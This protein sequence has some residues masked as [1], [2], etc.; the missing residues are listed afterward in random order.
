MRPTALYRFVRR[1]VLLLVTLPAGHLVTA[2]SAAGGDRL[3]YNRDVRPILAENCFA[4]HGPDSAA[5]KAGLRLDR[6]DEAVK[7]EAIVPGDPEKSG[8]IERIFSDQPGQMMPPRKTHKTLTA[9]QKDTLRRW[10]ADGA[11]YQP[12]WSLIA[13]KR[14][15]LPAV[16]DRGWV[17]NPVDAFI[18]AELEK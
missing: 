6:R 17:R 9:A 8:L 11:E 12:H 5:R 2:S 18:L 7:A 1:I 4:C 14:P 13:P 10:I 16:Q 15:P 3:E